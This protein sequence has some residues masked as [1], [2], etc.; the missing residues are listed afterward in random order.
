MLAALL[1]KNGE[2]PQDTATKVK[3]D[4]Y[5]QLTAKKDSY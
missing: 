2:L 1:D 5:V 4:Q 3:F